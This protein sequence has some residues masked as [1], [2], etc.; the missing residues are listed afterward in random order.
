MQEVLFSKIHNS[1]LISLQL[2]LISLFIIK[3]KY[4]VFPKYSIGVK[5]LSSKLSHM[6]Y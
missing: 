3:L 5:Y 6:N 2:E 4:E 1:Q